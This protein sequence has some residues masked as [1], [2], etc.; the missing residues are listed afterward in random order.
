MVLSTRVRNFNSALAKSRA[1]VERLNGELMTDHDL[2][3]AVPAEVARNA[4]IREVQQLL[5]D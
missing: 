2:F 1:K 5:T 3:A 4:D